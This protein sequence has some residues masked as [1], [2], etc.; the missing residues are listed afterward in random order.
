MLQK[1]FIFF[2]IA[3]LFACNTPK[4]MMQNM[5]PVNFLETLMQQHP[6]QFSAIL[7][8]ML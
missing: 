8:I 1:M 7:Q 6:D 5:L 4:K 3:I 2:I